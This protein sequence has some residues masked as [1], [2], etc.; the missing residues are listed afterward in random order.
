VYY[1]H[2]PDPPEVGNRAYNDFF[3]GTDGVSSLTVEVAAWR[4][5]RLDFELRLRGDVCAGGGEGQ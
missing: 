2:L 4:S 3:N 1:R 5:N